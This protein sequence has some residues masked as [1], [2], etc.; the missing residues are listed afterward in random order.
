ME[1]YLLTEA[2]TD[3]DLS[4]TPVLHIGGRAWQRIGPLPLDEPTT[5]P[6]FA[7]ISY[8]WGSGRVPNP[9]DVG[10]HMSDQTLLSLSAAIKASTVSTF[11]IDAFC[12]PVA[13]P[14]RSATLESMGY[15]YSIAKEVIVALSPDR[16]SALEEMGQSD[17]LNEQT[18]LAL[19]HDEWV[20]SVWTYQEV[21]NSQ[22][23]YFTT[24]NPLSSAVV[25][26]DTFLNRIGYTLHLY[27]QERGFNSFDLRGRLRSL[28]ALNDLIG[29]WLVSDYTD[30]SAL[31][32]MSNLDQRSCAVPQNY[33]YSMIGSITQLPSY[34]AVGM[35][36]PDLVEKTMQICEQKNDY[37]FIFSTATR[38]E[39]STRP[40]RP[41][42]EPLHSI[43]PY[44]PYGAR[45]GGRHDAHGFW[46]EKMVCLRPV[47]KVEDA[48]HMNVQAWLAKLPV[49][50][51][52]CNPDTALAND[53]PNI[54]EQIGFTGS[55]EYLET[56][57]GIF[58]PQQ[59]LSADHN[60]DVYILLATQVSW[61]FCYPA[62]VKARIEGRWTYSPGVFVGVVDKS[63]AA[64]YLL[65]PREG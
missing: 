7:C 52:S 12:I 8:V 17:K 16:S 55:K 50:W 9:M 18:L 53:I 61:T 15:I 23:L 43:L 32:V 42:P 20:R 39:L 4:A 40:W 58:Y 33:Y 30:R 35:Q 56:S 57:V 24:T 64:D 3:G 31:Q 27:K 14:S 62:V 11:W 1:L 36:I 22:M 25:E 34:R 48:D 2:I 5:R 54:L 65:H 41:R 37:S 46:L 13:Q 49:P 63:T 60:H 26:G 47:N 6:E 45:Q 21:V 19:E 44:L 59:F 10:K 28:E 29:D 38:N 51:S